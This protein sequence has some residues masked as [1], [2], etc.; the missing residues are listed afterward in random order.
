MN[1]SK[2]LYLK[3]AIK[4]RNVWLGIAMIW[5]VVYHSGIDLGNNVFGEIM[6]IGY[7]GVD[8]CIYICFWLRLLLFFGKKS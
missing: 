5:I 3:D 2:S 6:K 8:I 4:Y 1:N 7:G